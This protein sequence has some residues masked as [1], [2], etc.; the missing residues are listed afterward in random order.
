MDVFKYKG[1]KY[2]IQDL[3]LQPEE[4][5]SKRKKIALKAFRKKSNQSEI[6]HGFFGV[7]CDKEPRISGLCH[8]CY[9]K[10]QHLRGIN[11]FISEV[12]GIRNMDV[13]TSNILNFSQ[14]PCIK[15]SLQKCKLHFLFVL[16]ACLKNMD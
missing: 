3:L 1:Q 6:C 14:S 7:Q 5:L 2:N 13:S 9:R 15:C 16:C 12:H 10:Q 8:S 11:S 4:S